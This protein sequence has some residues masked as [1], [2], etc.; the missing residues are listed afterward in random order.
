MDVSQF[1]FVRPLWLLALLPWLLI[2]LSLWRRHNHGG[3]W[4]KIIDPRLRPFVLMGASSTRRSRLALWLGAIVAAL[5]ILAQ[6]GPVWEKRPQPLFQQQSAL[7]IALDLSRSMDAG[8]LSPSRLARARFKVNDILD[9]RKDGQ[10]ALL[11][12]AATPFTVTPLTDDVKTIRSLLPS[13]S[14][15]MMPAQGSRADRA[16]DKAVELMKN[17]GQLHGD[18][19]LLT[20]GAGGDARAAAQTARRQGYRISVLAI[21]SREGAPVPLPGGGF[22]KDR[23]GGIVIPKLDSASLRQ[24]AQLGGGG[25]MQLS[26][27]DND[28]NTLLAP[29]NQP[30]LDQPGKKTT[31][32]TDS[33][34][35][36]G[37]WLLLLAL[38]LA[39][40]LFRRGEVFLLLV[41]LLPLPQPAQAFE[42]QD[43]WLNK[44]QQAEKLMQQKKPEVAAEKFTD[45]RWK[46]AAQYRAGHYPQAG[47][48]LEKFD[49]A[50]SWYNRGNALAKAGQL[51]QAL[52][53]YEEA[54]KRNPQLDDAGYNKQ[55]IEKALQQQQKQQQKEQQ[56]QGQQQGQPSSQQQGQDAQSQQS[57]DSQSQKSQSQDSKPQ[58]AKGSAA[59]EKKQD[60]S[61]DSSAS[62][63]TTQQQSGQAED[64]KTSAA[65]PSEEEKDPKKQ[66]ANA[67]QTPA[68]K[69]PANHAPEQNASAAD[70]ADEQPLTDEQ[71][72]TQQWLRR[73]PDDPGGLLRRKFRYQYQQQSQ[74]SQESQPW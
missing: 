41:F 47:K 19:L 46:A 22:L 29:I 12:W 50:D 62:D 20:D 17:A 65:K 74:D 31:L 15:T 36:Q 2:L 9:R 34:Y 16:I 10:T 52:S 37:P 26:A 43:L 67:E 21:G 44:N 42:W 1:H 57:K 59:Q 72:A 71:R 25:F 66:P 63:T 51:P 7:V 5:M 55:L 33:W 69:P 61:K 23:D 53:A 32:N 13:L 4:E 38:P 35:E 49:D 28:V 73:I 70:T 54:L 11:V 24:L 39:A 8:D 40:L 6:A 58:D 60:P 27:N 48:T 68:T 3:V 56:K 14:T 30:H 18:I 45:P 64:K